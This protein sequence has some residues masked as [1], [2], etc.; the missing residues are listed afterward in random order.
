M[1]RPQRP[2]DEG[3]GPVAEF[4]SSLRR[5]RERTGGRSY[6]ELSKLANCAPSTLSDA[7]A[8][9]RLPSW[10]VVAGF[11][12]ACEV[13]DEGPWRERWQAAADG[14][15]PPTRAGHVPDD[16]A[17]FVGRGADLDVVLKRLD[18]SRLVTITG[19]GGAGKTRLAQRAAHAAALDHADG[20][21][22]VELS[23][24]TD[25]SLIPRAILSTLDIPPEPARP[26]REQL[27]DALA[28]RYLLIILDNCEHL[29]VECAKLVR[30]ILTSTTTVSIL[31][32]SRRALALPE[33]HLCPI[34]PLPM[35][36]AVAL[37]IERARAV[38]PGFSPTEADLE[39]AELLCHRLDG[40]PL[41]IEFAARRLRTFTL[42]QLCEFLDA[43]S[44]LLRDDSG[45]RHRRQASVR[46]TLE[47]SHDL[48]SPE[49]QRLWRDLSVYLGGAPLAA[50][51]S[52]AGPEALGAVSELVDQSVLV[53]AGRRLRMLESV[54]EYG[55]WRL[56][57][58]GKLRC[59][60]DRH[61]GWCLDYAE[62][63]DAA[64]YG[65]GQLEV[66]NRI[67]EEMPNLRAAMDHGLSS[68]G[69]AAVRG[70]RIAVSLWWYWLASGLIDEGRDWLER[71]LKVCGDA[72]ESV[73]ALWACGYVSVLLG[74][75]GRTRELC[76]EA[77]AS[78]APKALAWSALIRGLTEL[79]SG[80]LEQ[81]VELTADALSRFRALGDAQGVQHALSQ[82]GITRAMGGDQAAA[83]SS[84]EEG[85]RIAAAHGERWHRAYLLWTQGWLRVMG[86]D[87]RTALPLL[88]ESLRIQEDFA[89]RR[90]I[91]ANLEALG[92]VAAAVGDDHRAA[93]LLGRA[94]WHWS[95]VEARL[96]GFAVLTAHAERHDAALR[97]RMPAG[98]F[99]EAYRRGSMLSTV[100]TWAVVDGF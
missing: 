27:M 29:A 80:T 61:L 5:L 56:S 42:A 82:L 66:L 89:D 39:I 87:P 14:T 98:E 30:D 78:G 10:P 24:V 32:T 59:A 52:T 84:V 12:R 72:P 26:P 62:N 1:G 99:E 71:S 75:I 79:V 58:S 50:V 40:L 94:H 54:R 76:D 20:A 47:W 6:R 8:G 23:D 28:K 96:F 48:C 86:D 53:S 69:D 43:P 44:S 93:I 38:L 49:A 31:A 15:R 77:A 83:V 22:W 41:A 74:E 33:E 92:W 73:D 64:W 60:R 67:R 90:A 21:R 100:D 9:R 70:L 65:P 95:D 3:G 18:R 55:L 16:P 35:S 68:G 17:T 25:A 13:S 85:R 19:P 63:A 45:V 91:A 88:R 46:A 36:Q 51:Q 81:A 11:L 2:I 97:E 37:L 34:G 7:T 4:A 57:S